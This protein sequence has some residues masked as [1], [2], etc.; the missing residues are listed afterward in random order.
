MV[1]YSKFDLI[2]DSDD[3]VVNQSVSKTELPARSDP[4]TISCKTCSK[5]CAK[6]L[7]CSTCRAVTYCSPACQKEDW[8]WHKRTCKKPMPMEQAFQQKFPGSI[9]LGGANTNDQRGSTSHVAPSQNEFPKEVFA[10]SQKDVAA[11]EEVE[12]ICKDT[13]PVIEELSDDDVPTIDAGVVGHRFSELDAMSDSTAATD[14]LAEHGQAHPCSNF[15]AHEKDMGSSDAAGG[16]PV[17]TEICKN[18]DALN[19]EQVSEVCKNCLQT[20]AKSFKCGT[21]KVVIYCSAKCQREDWQFHKRSCKKAM[22]KVL[23]RC[24]YVFKETEMFCRTCGGRRPDADNLAKGPPMRPQQSVAEVVNETEVDGWYRHREW[25]PEE[26]KEFRPVRIDAEE[27]ALLPESP[28]CIKGEQPKETAIASAFAS[29]T[30][31]TTPAESATSA[32][33]PSE[34]RNMISWWSQR[35][36]SLQLSVDEPELDVKVEPITDITG[37]ASIRRSQG[38]SHC[39]FDIEFLVQ[40]DVEKQETSASGFP[41]L[42][43]S[44][45]QVR[46]SQFSQDTP[47]DAKM[48]LE[49]HEIATTIA[50]A[51]LVPKLR[52]ALQEC[53]IAFESEQ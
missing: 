32:E 23:C 3:E 13:S 45:G 48:E 33:A 22:P 4:Q 53:A 40:F 50:E 20:C 52:K 49:G 5:V 29:E 17:V 7:M 8:Q 41:M 21:C 14:S 11:V 15:A 43:T 6:P 44:C 34:E 25:Q 2:E 35:L 12:T 42:T 9:V 24:G 36:S 51:S 31:C 18:W 26:K 19:K 30:P 28:G 16:N 1:D 46:V 37:T 27:Q 39:V 38:I 47:H 10:S